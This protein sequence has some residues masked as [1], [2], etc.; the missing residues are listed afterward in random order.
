MAHLTANLHVREDDAI[1]S[2][3]HY[4]DEGAGL[5]GR[6]AI[7]KLT[8]FVMESDTAARVAGAFSDLSALLLDREQKAGG[9]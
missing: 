5:Y 7:G 2:G 6:V 9:S 8:I 3:I 1:D 4:M